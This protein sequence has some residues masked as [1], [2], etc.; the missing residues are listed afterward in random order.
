MSGAAREPGDGAK[1][2]RA[3]QG[4]RKEATLAIA[5]FIDGLRGLR[6]PGAVA[7]PYHADR[8]GVDAGPWAAEQ[9]C[10]QLAAFLAERQ[11]HARLLLVGEAPGYQGARFTGVPMTSERLL[12][13]PAGF[14]V[15]GPGVFRR[16]SDAAACR[17]V[18]GRADGF[19]EPT[20]T[21]VWQVL[22]EAGAER[23]AVLWNAFPQHPYRPGNPLSNRRPTAAELAASAAVLPRFLALFPGCRVI[24]LGTVARD[25]L[26]AMGVTAVAVRHPANGGVGAFRA[27]MRGVLDGR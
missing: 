27:G 11:G 21:V 12:A 7:N 15:L 3:G 20:A 26:A 13:G 25:L 14:R 8:P 10:A 5:A 4:A 22:A 1:V 17:T 16:T 23:A 6:L 2:A 18:A 9:R 19:A 24:A